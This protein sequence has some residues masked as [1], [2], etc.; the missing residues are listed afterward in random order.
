MALYRLRHAGAARRPHARSPISASPSSTFPNGV[1]L[2]VK[3]TDFRDEQILVSVRTGIGELGLP[4]DRVTS[5][6]M[7]GSVIAPGGLGKLTV[8]ELT[9]VLSGNDLQRQLLG[10]DSDA[11]HSRGATRPEDLQLEM[12]VLTAYLTDPGLRPRRSN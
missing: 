12:Q 5:M 1:R 4:T 3:P 7:A 10:I 11:Y 2:T 8:D 9:R 6:A